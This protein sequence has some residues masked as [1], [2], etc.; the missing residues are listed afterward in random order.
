MVGERY[1]IQIKN[2][3]TDGVMDLVDFGEHLFFVNTMYEPTLFFP[4]LDAKEL[5]EKVEAVL[6]KCHLTN[7]ANI[8]AATFT[9]YLVKQWSRGHSNKLM[10]E[11]YEL[12]QSV[13]VSN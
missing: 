13:P 8:G 11:S 1:F 9:V 7:R 10:H 4:M 12:V 3:Q 5:A 6:P 2:N